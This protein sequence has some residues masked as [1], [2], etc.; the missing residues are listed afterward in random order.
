VFFSPGSP[1]E[2]ALHGSIWT[3]SNSVMPRRLSAARQLES[4]RTISCIAAYSLGMN[5]ACT[6]G[7]TCQDMSCPFVTS[8]IASAVWRRLG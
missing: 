6:P 5:G 1:N 3:L 7:T 2:P 4:A 8:T